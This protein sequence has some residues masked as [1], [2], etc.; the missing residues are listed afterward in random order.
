M[1]FTSPSTTACTEKSGAAF[2]INNDPTLPPYF[3]NY[4]SHQ[5]GL[6]P[7]TT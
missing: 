1:F 6:E 5:R 7:L 3:L 2:P 4:A